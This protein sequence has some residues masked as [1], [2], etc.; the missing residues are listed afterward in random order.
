MARVTKTV[1]IDKSGGIPERTFVKN[2]H[3][4]SLDTHP[5]PLQGCFFLFLFFFF[6]TALKA[7]KHQQG[8]LLHLSIT[9]KLRSP[10]SLSSVNSKPAHPPTPPPF[11]GICWA[12]DNCSCPRVDICYNRSVLGW[13]IGNVTFQFLIKKCIFQCAF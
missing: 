8:W 4:S 12:F 1:K 13:G 10:N 9:H 7:K 3:R 5:Q 2:V 6:C 11:L